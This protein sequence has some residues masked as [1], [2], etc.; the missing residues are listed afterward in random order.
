MA[1]E[2]A[3]EQAL[4]MQHA[5]ASVAL[6][7]NEIQMAIAEAETEPEDDDGE[8]DTGDSPPGWHP[9]PP[10]PTTTATAAARSGCTAAGGVRERPCQRCDMGMRRER[11]RCLRVARAH[12]AMCTSCLHM[13]P[14]VHMRRN[15]SCTLS[16]ACDMMHG[17]QVFFY[18]DHTVR[19]P[20]TTARPPN[21]HGR[22]RGR[23][24][25]ACHCR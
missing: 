1:A 5:D 24:E 23:E 16:H 20:R 14:H 18:Y 21:A 11:C 25:A 8:E 9:P 3:T 22:A 6:T 10:P 17:S 7:L 15:H 4:F 19:H 2:Q 12:V 13:M